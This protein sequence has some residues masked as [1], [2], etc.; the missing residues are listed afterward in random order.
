[1]NAFLDLLFRCYSTKEVNNHYTIYNKSTSC[2]QSFKVWF[3]AA[4]SG[5]LP[6]TGL[7]HTQEAD[8]LMVCHET[9]FQNNIITHIYF[10]LEQPA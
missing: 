8:S 9:T 1:M 2:L 4:L 10:H 6:L 7:N 3:S 5:F